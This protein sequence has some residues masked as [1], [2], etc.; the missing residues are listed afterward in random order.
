VP[1]PGARDKAALAALGRDVRA[2]LDAWFEGPG[3]QADW[4]AR[5]EVYYGEQTLQQFLERTTWHAGQ[6]TRQLMWVLEGLGIA[7]DRPLGP[8]TFAG[9]PMPE[10]VWD[11]E[12]LAS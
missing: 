7:P 2:R 9:L 8:E 3:R 11:G 12:A 6:H 4:N 1:A 10:K 5:A